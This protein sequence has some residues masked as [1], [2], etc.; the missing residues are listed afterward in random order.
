VRISQQGEDIWLSLLG[1]EVISEQ[2]RI[3]GCQ[4]QGGG[5]GYLSGVRIFGCQF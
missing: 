4:F 5:R 2:G 1:R 3:F